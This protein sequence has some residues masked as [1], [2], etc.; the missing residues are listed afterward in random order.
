MRR[1]RVEGE[2]IYYLAPAECKAA[3]LFFL[4]K[5]LG[6]AVTLLSSFF[7]AKIRLMENVPAF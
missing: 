3:S 1:E 7:L 6:G 5:L 4:N 2:F